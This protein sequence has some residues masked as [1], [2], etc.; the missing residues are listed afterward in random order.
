[1]LKNII[2]D[3][4]I[5]LMEISAVIALLHTIGTS[6]NGKNHAILMFVFHIS[7]NLTDNC[8]HTQL[9]SCQIFAA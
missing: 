6:C 3:C 5:F 2:I 1:M 9:L 4:L 7:Y 8:F